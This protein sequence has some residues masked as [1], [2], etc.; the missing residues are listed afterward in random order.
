VLWYYFELDVTSRSTAAD[1]FVDIRKFS[2][3]NKVALTAVNLVK[4]S[5]GEEGTQAI[6]AAAFK[7]KEGEILKSIY[8][9][10][11]ALICLLGS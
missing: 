7:G 1:V 10:T 5:I 6:V 9:A 4:N 2:Q 8:G 11:E 3:I